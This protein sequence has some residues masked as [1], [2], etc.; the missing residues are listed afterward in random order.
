MSGC[1]S[2][3]RLNGWDGS[4]AE[5]LWGAGVADFGPLRKARERSSGE[6]SDEVSG[7]EP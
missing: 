4:E 6:I 2:L 5:I 7:G 3:L 1:R